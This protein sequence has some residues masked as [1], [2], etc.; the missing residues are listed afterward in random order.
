[1]NNL[2]SGLVAWGVRAAVDSGLL[3]KF[4]PANNT[5]VTEISSA[6]EPLFLCDAKLIDSFGMGPLIPNTGLFHT[7]SS[8]DEYLIIA[9][10]ADRQKMD[11]PD[12]YAQ[13]L[14]D[15][16]CELMDAVKSDTKKRAKI[17][18]AAI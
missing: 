8:T 7:V 3:E 17:D 12:F 1:M 13:C 10:T 2:Y 18:K 16:F 14:Q 6:S 15:S 5:I 9:F 4:P 11:D